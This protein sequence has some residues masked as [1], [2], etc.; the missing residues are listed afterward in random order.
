MHEINKINFEENL[1]EYIDEF[2]M[3]RIRS[4]SDIERLINS[5]RYMICVFNFKTN[6]INLLYSGDYDEICSMLTKI[7]Q[8]FTTKLLSYLSNHNE[9]AVKNKVNKINQDYFLKKILNIFYYL[10]S[11]HEFGKA[12]GFQEETGIEVI[13]IILLLKNF[14]SKDLQNLLNF[15]LKSITNLFDDNIFLRDCI[16]PSILKNEKDLSIFLKTFFNRLIL[17]RNECKSKIEK[18]KR[19]NFD[20]NSLDYNDIEFNELKYCLAEN[21]VFIAH[22]YSYK[23]SKN[24][25]YTENIKVIIKNSHNILDKELITMLKELNLEEEILLFYF[26]KGNYAKCISNIVSIYDNINSA[27]NSEDLGCE[28]DKELNIHTD[29]NDRSSS[30]DKIKTQWFSRYINLI[31][32]ISDKISPLEFHEYIKWALSKNPFKTI[33]TL[34][35][36]S[37]ISKEKLDLDFINLLKTYGIDPVIYYLK[38]FIKNSNENSTH[39]NEMINL[40]TIKLKLLIETM[41]KEMNDNPNK[42]ENFYKWNK[43]IMKTRDEFCNFLIENKFYDLNF[44]YENISVIKQLNVECGIVL[45]KQN[46]L[47]EGIPKILNSDYPAGMKIVKNIIKVYPNYDFIYLIMKNIINSDIEEKET[48]IINLLDVIKDRYDLLL[49]NMLNLGNFQFG[50]FERFEAE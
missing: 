9:K 16:E 2:H 37:K 26:Y 11:I 41:E 34:F 14:I 19:R 45:I 44:A 49:V 10:I 17:Y 36:N 30:V 15:I 42:K 33:N 50:N 21:I 7:N 8:D 39:H 23:L 12:K 1:I 13:F 25:K 32:L 29:D 28:F 40:Y 3:T 46:K 20:F 4:L 43:K 35:E 6:K 48:Q 47:E 31:S 18:D 22:F 24:P 27:N 38:H 5:A